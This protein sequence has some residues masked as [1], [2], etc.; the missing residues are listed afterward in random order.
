[1]SRLSRALTEWMARKTWASWRTGIEANLID[2]CGG[3]VMLGDSLTHIGRWELMFPDSA[4]RNLGIG[5][6]RSDHLLQRLEPVVRIRPRQ[7][8]LLIGTND[9]GSGIAPE[10]IAGNV[11]QLLD[12][13]A[14]RLP[15]CTLHLQSLLPRARKFAPRIRQ[16]NALYAQIA[17]QRGLAFI[18]LYPLFDD[19]SGELRSELTYDRLH[20]MGAGYVV[21]RQALAPYILGA[22]R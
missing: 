7:L 1:M 21:W 19:G 15:D 16:L 13:L 11:A 20:L 18:D 22:A 6:E 9:L 17:T 8:F 10:L 12:T 5:G 3:V 14:Q 2:G 4:L